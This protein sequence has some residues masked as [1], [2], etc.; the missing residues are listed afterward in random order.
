VFNSQDFAYVSFDPVLERH[1]CWVF[2]CEKTGH[3]VANALRST[4]Y[5]ILKENEA[6]AARMAPALTSSQN[7]GAGRLVYESQ[8]SRESNRS[9]L[10]NWSEGI[11][12]ISYRLSL[13]LLLNLN[14][15]KPVLL[16]VASS[17]IFSFAYVTL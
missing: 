2:S 15:L 6:F 3:E 4:C 11:L 7:P 14:C 8:I 5:K 13:C 12:H 10:R 16:I 1:I 9:H 17:A